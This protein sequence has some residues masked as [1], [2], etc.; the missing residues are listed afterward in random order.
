MDFR[1]KKNTGGTFSGSGAFVNELPQNNATM[2]ADIEYYLPR[3]DII[4]LDSV[5]QFGTVQGNPSTSPKTGA[6]PLNAMPIYTMTLNAGTLD[7][8]DINLEFVENRRYTMR[9]IGKLET[10][11]SRVEEWATLS[12]LETQTESLEVLDNSGN[13]R[14]KSGFFVDNFKSHSFADYENAEYK[15]S[16]D[17]R[18]GIVRPSFVSRNIKMLYKATNSE[19]AASSNVVLKGDALMMSYTEEVEI[20]QP[21]A[22]SAI[23]VNPYSVFTGTGLITLSPNSD[24]WHDVV[25]T[26]ELAT[27][28]E[29]G[30]VNPVVVN[31]WNNWEWNWFG[32][33]VEV[34]I[35]PVRRVTRFGAIGR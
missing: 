16:I 12:L 30:A 10:R 4:Y 19:A 11:I 25:T 32:W 26:T 13:A 8:Y 9:D 29:T 21:L 15:A 14:F 5:G 27:I 2:Q 35:E 7:E 34:P 18:A 1:P 31:N 3:K 17:L 23:N 22:S 20:S 28:Q 33:N 24:D 6:V